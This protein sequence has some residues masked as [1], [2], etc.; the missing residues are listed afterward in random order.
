MYS[1]DP[2]LERHQKIKEIKKKEKE[3]E[4]ANNFPLPSHVETLKF[5]NTKLDQCTSIFGHPVATPSLERPVH[6]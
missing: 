3:R 2:D 6:T 4:V 1:L 5:P